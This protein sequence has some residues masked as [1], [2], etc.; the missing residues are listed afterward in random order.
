MTPS[1]P[2]RMLAVVAALA[3]DPLATLADAAVY[4]A[5]LVALC[6]LWRLG[7]VIKAWIRSRLDAGRVRRDGVD[8]LWSEFDRVIAE[9]PRTAPLP[10]RGIR[11]RPRLPRRPMRRP[12]ST[13]NSERH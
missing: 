10:R 3:A 9:A 8:P 7:A 13:S 4:L 5:V 1:F 2:D 11:R 6:V 12:T